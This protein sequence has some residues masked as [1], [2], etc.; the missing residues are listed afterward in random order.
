[1]KNEKKFCKI[2]SDKKAKI[3]INKAKIAT[4]EILRECEATLETMNEVVDAGAYF[5]KLSCNQRNSQTEE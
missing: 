4:K 1:M 3:L 2:V 5:V